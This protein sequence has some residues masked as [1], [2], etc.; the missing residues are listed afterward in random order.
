MKK[1]KILI[2]VLTLSLCSAMPCYAAV[3]PRLFKVADVSKDYVVFVDEYGF[4]WLWSD[5]DDICLNEYYSAVL[6]DVGTI[7]WYDDEIISIHYERLDLFGREVA[8]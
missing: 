6:D 2:A 1:L 3:Y 8:R 5:P 7:E 4:K